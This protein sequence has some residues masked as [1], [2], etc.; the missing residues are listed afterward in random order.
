MSDGVLADHEL[1]AAVR[2]GWIGA[3]PPITDEQFQPASLDLRLGTAAYQ[4]RASFLPVDETVQDRLGSDLAQS[5][6][7]IDRVALEPG[8]TFQRGSVYL[9][10]LLE[11]LRLPPHVRGRSN[12]KSTTGRLDIFTRVITDRTPRFDEIRLLS[13]R[14]A[15][16]DPELARVYRASPLLHDDAGR[17]IP[18]ERAGFNDGLCM[19]L[20]LSGRATDGI[21]GYR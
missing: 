10:P 15:M 8:A 16:S 19:G 17:P 14:T 13:G 12:P 9:V 20:D 1:R 18:I 6:L 4:L 5:D 7:V 11:S 3:A 2:E 21:I